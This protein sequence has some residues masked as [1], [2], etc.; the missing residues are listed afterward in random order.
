MNIK[1]I[2]LKAIVELQTEDLTA[3]EYFHALEEMRDVVDEHIVEA[4]L[5]WQDRID[6]TMALADKTLSEYCG[7][8]GC[9]LP[10]SDFDI[11]SHEPDCPRFP[12]LGGP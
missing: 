9:K 11:A 10:D 2:Q 3:L 12:A 6:K 1:T 8:C 7:H 5:E 4:R